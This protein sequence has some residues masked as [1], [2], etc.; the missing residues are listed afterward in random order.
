MCVFFNTESGVLRNMEMVVGG[1]MVNGDSD[2]VIR[3]GGSRVGG[4]GSVVSLL[5]G[6]STI[7]FRIVG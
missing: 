1:A 7:R 3:N 5:D 6:H 4:G 2:G